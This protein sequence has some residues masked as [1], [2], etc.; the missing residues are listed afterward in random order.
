MKSIENEKYHFVYHLCGTGVHFYVRYLYVYASIIFLYLYLC[1]LNDFF[2]FK[3][4]DKN[5]YFIIQK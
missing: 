5:I 4:I 3:T 2:I 1:D